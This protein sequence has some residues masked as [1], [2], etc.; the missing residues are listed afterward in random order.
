MDH[1]HTV[2]VTGA[3]GFIGSHVCGA[4]LARGHVV[5]GLDNFDS[6]YPRALKE[7]NVAEVRAAHPRGAMEMVEGDAGDAALVTA[8][9]ERT[10][11][12]GVI[13]LGAR[14]G[15]RPSIEMPALY[16]RVNIEATAVML[17][18]ARRSAGCGRFVLASSSS[19]YGNLSRAP[20]SEDDDVSFP[21]SPYAATKRACELMGATFSHLYGLPT[22]CLRFFTVFGPRQRPSLA[23][24]MFIEKIARG[25]PIPVFGDGSTSRD[26]TYIDD[27]VSG[28]LASY[29]RVPDYRYR[30]WNLG[31]SHPVTLTE[32][33]DTIARVVGK[34]AKI[35]RLPS[36][37]GDVE[38][39]FADPTRSRAELGY[40]PLTSFEDGVR[41]QWEWMRGRQA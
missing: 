20:F 40:A 23:I 7:R 26:Y 5:V 24:S 32:M 8:L 37:P 10:R 6:V 2:L 15:V 17:E 28:V 3:A 29:D 30:V 41:R 35:E 11:P 34:P 36:Q 22:A 14:G 27:I 1:G 31:N 39:T 19:V 12:S 21:I 18:A 38:R 33:I 13:H 16:C 25:E 4:L 9:M